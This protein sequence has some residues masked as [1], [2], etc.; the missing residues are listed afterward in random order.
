[1]PVSSDVAGRLPSSVLPIELT[2]IFRERVWGRK[3][4]TPFFP[5]VAAQDDKGLIGEVWF[6]FEENL[7]SLGVSLGNLLRQR[8]ELL[9][10]ATDPKHPGMCPLLVKL[11]FTTERLSVQVHPDDTYAERHH[12]SLGKTEAWYVVDA[13]LGAEVA[14]GFRE[15]LTAE[16]LKESAQSGEIERLLA[17]HKVKTG[18][19]V[20]VP[21]GTVHAIGAGLTICEVQENSDITYRLYDYGR[22]RELHLEHGMAVSKLEPYSPLQNATRIGE[23]RDA[24][25]ASRY[26]RM[27]RLKPK[28]MFNV[29]AHLPYYLLMICLR[30]EGTIAGSAFRAGQGWFVPSGGEAFSVEGASEW[31]LTYTADEAVA[32]IRV[33]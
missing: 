23:G 27:E 11:I 2:P 17:W 22:P 13:E 21:A 20:F 10:V 16:R 31:L 7:T 8:P 29:P 30:G 9:G 28:Y 33:E 26:F 25:M 15:P 5:Q 3:S 14:V 1:M 12:G 32:G 6:T 19:V 4:L 18:D 24:L